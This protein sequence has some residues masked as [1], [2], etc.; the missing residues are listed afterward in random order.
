MK[1]P[2][3]DDSSSWHFFRFF[4]YSINVKAIEDL[5]SLHYP[6]VKIQ[7][8]FQYVDACEFQMSMPLM[9]CAGRAFLY[10]MSVPR[11]SFF[12]R[13]V[14]GSPKL[15]LILQSW[16]LLVESTPTH[17]HI[18]IIVQLK[19]IDFHQRSLSGCEASSIF[20]YNV[21]N[22]PTNHVDNNWYVCSVKYVFQPTG[23][24]LV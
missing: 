6:R 12:F 7:A 4:T 2:R 20:Y 18:C 21:F 14:F 5:K 23:C 10:F 19:T 1:Q 16:I 8:P 13:W 9:S 3:Q 22:H 17:R 11:P 15:S 24:P